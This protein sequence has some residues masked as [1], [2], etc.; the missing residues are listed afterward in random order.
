MTKPNYSRKHFVKKVDTSRAKVN[1]CREK[2]S[3]LE[4][5]RKMDLEKASRIWKE[6]GQ[7]FRW[8]GTLP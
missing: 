6:L 2:F 5:Q 1:L 3:D 8:W 4:R 7:R